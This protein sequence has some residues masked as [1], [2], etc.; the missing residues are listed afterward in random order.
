MIAPACSRVCGTN[1][2]SQACLGSAAD[3]ARKVPEATPAG[4]IIGPRMSR[5]M[6]W[7]AM[8]FIMMVL[9][10]SF[11]FKRA[12]RMPGTK[13][14]AAPAMNPSA[15]VTG[16]KI[17]PG[18]V[19]KVSG[20]QVATIAPSVIWPSPPI[21]ITL[22]RNAIQMPNPTSRSGVALTRDWVTPERLPAAPLT[23]AA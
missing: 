22:A 20:N 16:I 18:Q 12:F 7:V 1:R 11:T 5:Y 21:L 3:W 17:Q 15:R 14:Q 2:G 8:E 13:P 6:N 19:G 10:I 4:S 9:R 23:M